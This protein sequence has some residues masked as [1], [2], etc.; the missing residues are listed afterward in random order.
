MFT[1]ENEQIRSIYNAAHARGLF[2]GY[3]HR[4]ETGIRVRFAL[5]SSRTLYIDTWEVPVHITKNPFGLKL[6]KC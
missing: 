1:N 5:G 4:R 2:L 6:G 3:L